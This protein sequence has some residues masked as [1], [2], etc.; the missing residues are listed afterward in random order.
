MTFAPKH[1]LAPLALAPEDDYELAEHAVD[2]ACDLAE[3][4][5]SQVT[6]LHLASLTSPAQSA[7]M[8]VSGKIYQTLAL[9]L[10]ARISRGRMKLAELQKRV[11]KRGIPVNS[12]VID[13]PESIAHAICDFAKNEKTDLILIGSHSRHGLKKFFLGSVAEKVVHL[14]SVPV[15]LLRDGKYEKSP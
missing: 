13:S 9:V 2:V 15:L 6:L 14:S 8:D 3:K 4:F 12:S 10:Q 11:E 1:I 7:V 5:G